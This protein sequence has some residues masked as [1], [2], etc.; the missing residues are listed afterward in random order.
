[1]IIIPND[2]KVGDR[3]F[4][5][6][7]QYKKDIKTNGKNKPNEYEYKITY[8]SDE[9]LGLESVIGGYNLIFN[10]DLIDSMVGEC[11]KTN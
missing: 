11:R 1:M 6:Y 3:V 5:W 9:R 7:S 10:K 2:L 8:V 4:F